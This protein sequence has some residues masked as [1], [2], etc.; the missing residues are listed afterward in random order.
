MLTEKKKHVLRT[1][2]ISDG[3]DHQRCGTLPAAANRLVKMNSGA[4]YA[5]YL[6]RRGPRW[7]RSFRRNS[8]T[9]VKAHRINN[10][11]TSTSDSY[12]LRGGVVTH[13]LSTDIALVKSSELDES[14]NN[15]KYKYLLVLLVLLALVTLIASSPLEMSILQIL[16][17]QNCN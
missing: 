13:S 15:M 11:I 2:L 14:I 5:L 3:R 9:T 10:Q 7:N 4:E 1:F 12:L 6:H 8:R 17:R 16:I